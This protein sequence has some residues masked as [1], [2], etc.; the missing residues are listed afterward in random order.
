L[1]YWSTTKSVPILAVANEV[2]FSEGAPMRVVKL[3]AVAAVCAV[4]SGTAYAADDQAFSALGG[5]EVQALSPSE[6]SGIYGQLTLAQ[7]KATVI[8][9]VQDP[10]TR[11]S[12]LSQCDR[13]AG[14]STQLLALL[15]LV[16]RGRY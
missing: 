9:Q 16:T 15:G 13:L 10:R 7:V 5:V 3:A 6:M 14:N 12:L 8:A 2:T 11:A 1:T 4:L